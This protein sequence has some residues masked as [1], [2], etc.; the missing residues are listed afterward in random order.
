MNSTKTCCT[1]RIEKPVTEYYK[2]KNR[3][4]G[5]CP[6]CKMCHLAACRSYRLNNPEKR[7]DT[8]SKYRLTSIEKSREYRKTNAE[9]MKEYGRQYREDN[10]EFCLMVVRRWGAANKEKK[11]EINRNW[12]NSSSPAAKNYRIAMNLRGRIYKA[13][14]GGYKPLSTMVLLGCDME[15]FKEYMT[16]LFTDGM[17]WDNHGEW[18]IDHI[19]PC[20]AFDL[21]DPEQQKICFHYTNLQPLWAADNLR[22]SDKLPHEFSGGE[23][24]YG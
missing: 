13:I 11:A 2:D 9:K 4:D 12:I 10:H 19:V 3:K 20:A 7:K 18:H 5:C 17:S 22:K 1:C 14:R 24:C 16:A 8:L 6:R 15:N 21:T 23:E